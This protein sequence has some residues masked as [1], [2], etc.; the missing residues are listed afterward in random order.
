MQRKE[1]LLCFVI[2]QFN[3]LEKTSYLHNEMKDCH[4]VLAFHTQ[5][6]CDGVER[7][8]QVDGRNSLVLRGG[9][10]HRHLL[11]HLRV[12]GLHRHSTINL[13]IFRK[14]QQKKLITFAL[15]R[16][17]QKVY[18]F[19]NSTQN[20]LG[21]LPE[22]LIQVKIFYSFIFGITRLLKSDSLILCVYSD[23]ILSTVMFLISIQSITRITLHRPA[24]RSACFLH[25]RRN[26][27][28]IPPRRNP[29]L[30]AT[31]R[32][33]LWYCSRWRETRAK[34]RCLSARCADV[35]CLCLSVV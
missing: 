18:I 3:S 5:R 17:D 9:H 30:Y 1:C 24:W 21:I 7:S 12:Q 14:L 4:G 15:N 23:E 25:W 8:T 33:S 10:Q 22:N 31:S 35:S 2:F 6:T 26:Q 34:E 19:L 29:A 11:T 16:W 32:E 13:Q 20:F 28:H 27:A